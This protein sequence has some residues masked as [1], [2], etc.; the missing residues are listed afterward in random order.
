[1]KQTLLIAGGS[2]VVG[3]QIAELF[4]ERN[5]AV[6]LLIAGRSADKAQAIA[7]R[8][9]NAAGLKL[10]VLANDPLADVGEH[11]DGIVVAVN[12]HHDRLLLAALQRAI[13][14]ADIARWTARLDDAR[15]LTQK[16][17]R[18][19]VVLASGWMAGAVATTIASMLGGAR[20]R[21]V[22]IDILF[23][24]ADKSGPD[25]VLGFVNMHQPF[26]IHDHGVERMVRSLSDG[27]MRHF[28]S[29]NSARVRRFS[30]PDQQSLVLA[31][32]ADGAAVRMAFDSTVAM[33]AF[34]ALV[35]SGLW[36]LIPA[37]L[38]Q[39]LLYNPGDGAAHQLVITAELD[40]KSLH[41]T[42]HDRLGQTHMTAAGAVTRSERLLGL[43]GRVH[44]PAGISYPE[45][46]ADVAAD[47]L[48]LK[49]MGVEMTRSGPGG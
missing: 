17:G 9:P 23:G 4:A 40:D 10:D 31:G 48:S 7:A 46:A 36:G 27:R 35:R 37:A 22:D 5:P 29:G 8:L 33:A 21:H 39:S 20:A 19:P 13:P 18:S 15:T 43:R 6:R 28:P 24:M 12:D 32:I 3:R 25:S 1:M 49:E 26:A 38:R 30:T 11:V 41:A 44:P 42:M 47:T 16:H 45:S 2:G 14:L 34:V